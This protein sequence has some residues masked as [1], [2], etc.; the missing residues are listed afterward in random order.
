M[1]L[2]AILLLL[3]EIMHV[4]SWLPCLWWLCASPKTWDKM[5]RKPPSC[6]L[7]R[8]FSCDPP[9]QYLPSSFLPRYIERG[10]RKG[11]E[12]EGHTWMPMLEMFWEIKPSSKDNYI[13]FSLETEQPILISWIVCVILLLM[14]EPSQ[15][16]SVSQWEQNSTLKANVWWSLSSRSSAALPTGLSTREGA[17]NPNWMG[18]ETHRL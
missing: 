4:P 11:E 10:Q 3:C 6:S 8:G 15:F 16:W 7:P 5:F 2:P 13:S 1:F 17:A 12:D 14:Y 18:E 9:W